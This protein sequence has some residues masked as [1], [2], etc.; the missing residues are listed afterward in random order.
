MTNENWTDLLSTSMLAQLYNL[1]TPGFAYSV[2][3]TFIAAAMFLMCLALTTYVVFNFI[4]ATILENFELSEEEKVSTQ[5]RKYM[6]ENE[7]AKKQ[8]SIQILYGHHRRVGLF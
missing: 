8:R 1:E 7:K 6:Q 2:I 3:R 4:I 5:F